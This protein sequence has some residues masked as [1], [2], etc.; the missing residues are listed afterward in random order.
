MAQDSFE[1]IDETTKECNTCNETKSVTDFYKHPEMALGR[2]N[3]CKSCYIRRENIKKRLKKGF[4][5]LRTDHCECCDKT[6]VKLQLDHCH[7][8]EKFRGFICRSCNQVLGNYGD[9]Y[10]SI[11]EADGLDEIYLRYMRTANYRMG[12]N[13]E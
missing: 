6:D 12:E 9:N 13:L 10:A 3:V 1:F 8:T 11:K 4:G 2:F 5:S 7:K